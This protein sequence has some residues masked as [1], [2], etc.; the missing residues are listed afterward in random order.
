[1]IAGNPNVGRR[2]LILSIVLMALIF[3]TAVFVGLRKRTAPE[4]NPPLHPAVFVTGKVVRD[5]CAD[6]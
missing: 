5:L 6:E 2:L 3:L 4:N 1:M